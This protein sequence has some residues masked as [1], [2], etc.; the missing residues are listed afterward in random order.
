M[1]SLDSSEEEDFQVV[2]SK[3]ITR[4]R[5][6]SEKDKKTTPLMDSESA[7][8]NVRNMIV[9]MVGDTDP[10]TTTEL[11]PA[12]QLNDQELVQRAE[13]VFNVYNPEGNPPGNEGGPK[14]RQR[15][16]GTP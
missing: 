5:K 1:S 11:V 4:K 8:N 3:K 9:S 7:Y 2:L 6:S 14:V 10:T 15:L 16:G 12:S 13:L